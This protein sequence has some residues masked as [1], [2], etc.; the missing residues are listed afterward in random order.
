MS[1]EVIRHLAI[2]FRLPNEVF[3]HF[4]VSVSQVR[5]LVRRFSHNFCIKCVIDSIIIRTIEY[6]FFVI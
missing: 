3:S 1:T 5:K 2:P 6:V 4:D